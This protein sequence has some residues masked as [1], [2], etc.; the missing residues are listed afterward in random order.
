MICPG[1]V[2]LRYLSDE[3]FLPS[4]RQRSDLSSGHRGP[5]RV[6]EGARHPLR[7]EVPGPDG[8]TLE[9]S[10]DWAGSPYTP[11]FPPSVRVPFRCVRWTPPLSGLD[12]PGDIAVQTLNG[13]ILLLLTVSSEVLL[14]LLEGPRAREGRV[15]LG[16]TLGS[17][18]RG[19]RGRVVG[20]WS[21]TSTEFPNRETGTC[22]DRFMAP[23]RPNGGFSTVRGPTPHNWMTTSSRESEIGEP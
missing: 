21:L 9:T 10:T 8:R 3:L 20:G 1:A 6:P 19:G 11:S 13:E 2:G 16:S 14:G 4:H 15:V 23:R 17:R 5:P 18:D 12:D 7:G 22:L